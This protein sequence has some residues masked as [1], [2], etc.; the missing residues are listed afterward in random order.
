MDANDIK[1]LAELRATFKN[2]IDRIKDDYEKKLAHQMAKMEEQLN[3]AK[4][5]KW[6]SICQKEITVDNDLDPSA[7][8]IDCWKVML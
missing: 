7:C 3:R 6:C 2:N 8:S 5:K 1:Y 4:L